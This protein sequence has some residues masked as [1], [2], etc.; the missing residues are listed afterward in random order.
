M[1]LPQWTHLDAGYDAQLLDEFHEGP[2]VISLLVQRL[3][4]EDH[5]GDIVPKFLEKVSVR[6]PQ[7]VKTCFSTRSI[8]V[9]LTRP[10]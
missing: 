4:E 8:H 2:A 9:Q 1:V 3:V 5:A 7:Y 6:L 10:W